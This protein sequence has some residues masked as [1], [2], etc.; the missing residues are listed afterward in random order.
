MVSSECWRKEQ[1]LLVFIE[2]TI[3]T[4]VKYLNELNGAWNAEKVENL[5]MAFLKDQLNVRFV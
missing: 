2:E 4:V 1:H 3:T 5:A